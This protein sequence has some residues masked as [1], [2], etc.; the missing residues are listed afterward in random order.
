MAIRREGVRWPRRIAPPSRTL[1]RSSSNTRLFT[2]ELLLDDFG[3]P[4]NLYRSQIRHRVLRIRVEQQDN[5][6]P[7]RP[8]VN[9][10][11]AAALSPRSNRDAD[12]ACPPP[13]LMRGPSSGFAASRDWNSPYSSS[14]NKAAICLVKVEVSISSTRHHYPPMADSGQCFRALRNPPKKT[15]GSRPGRASQALLP[16]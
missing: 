3:E 15:K 2:A 6:F 16:S 7:Y 4:R 13:P 12:L 1:S 14:L 10:A 11:C 8:I 9:D 5:V